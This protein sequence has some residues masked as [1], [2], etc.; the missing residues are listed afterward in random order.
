MQIACS[1]E[2]DDRQGISSWD[3]NLVGENTPYQALLPL[4]WTIYEGTQFLP[5]IVL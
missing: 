5:G 1:V 2:D 3:W 4:A